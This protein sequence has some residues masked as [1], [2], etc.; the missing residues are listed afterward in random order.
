MSIK[1]HLQGEKKLNRN[2]T[3]SVKIRSLHGAYDFTF[4]RYKANELNISDYSKVVR[5]LDETYQSVGLREYESRYG[6]KLSYNS[7][8][9]LLEEQSG[10]RLYSSGQLQ[11]KIK[12]E[13]SKVSDSQRTSYNGLQLC[14]PFV[15]NSVAIYDS[16]EEEVLFFDDGIGVKRQ[17]D[18]RNQS[19]YEKPTK[20]VQSDVFSL[21]QADGTYRYMTD[22]INEK[23]DIVMT[24]ED[25]LRCEISKSYEGKTMNL[26]AITDGAR[27]I[28]LRL[29][30][31]FG[32]F[33]MIILDWYHLKKRVNEVMSMMG[34]SKS[35]KEIHIKFILNHLWEG[36][37][38]ACLLYIEKEV[39]PPKWREIHKKNLLGYIEKHEAEII[40]Y[41]KR[42][43]AGKTIGSG[44]AES[45]VNQVVGMRQK[46]KGISWTP[47]GSKALAILKTLELNQEWKQYWGKMAA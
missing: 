14:F 22:L 40:N 21:E 34:L 10:V 38:A 24:G 26:V 45:S 44:R 39:Q 5:G 1:H 46:K 42:K 27:N 2:G 47:G 28:R 8:S 18:K 20:R 23:G 16:N 32:I 43:A 30:R 9:D 12:R 19:D 4:Q 33:V 15:N 36:K 29:W 25:V 41:E 6:N 3:K 11:R 35:M 37:V 13:A 17:K 31:V 7:L